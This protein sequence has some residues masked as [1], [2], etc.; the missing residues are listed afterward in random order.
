M[1]R[2]IKESS[3]NKTS[4]LQSELFCLLF[5]L[6]AVND[7]TVNNY[8]VGCRSI[9]NDYKQIYLNKNKRYQN[10]EKEFC[11]SII[12][13]LNVIATEVDIHTGKF[14]SKNCHGKEKVIMYRQKF[15]NK[16][17]NG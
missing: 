4:A 6:D 2:I 14:L 10:N 3:K 9:G 15:G 13:I 8:C 1:F 17:I 12:G 5:D 16:K 11:N 7:T